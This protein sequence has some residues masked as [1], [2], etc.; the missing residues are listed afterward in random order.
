MPQ[1]NERALELY[2]SSIE[3]G[4]A[5][6]MVNLGAAHMNGFGIVKQ[7]F[8]EAQRLFQVPT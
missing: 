8:A 7:S 2:K 5:V 3:N 4:D 6:A 1:S